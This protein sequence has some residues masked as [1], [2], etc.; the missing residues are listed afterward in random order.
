VVRLPDLASGPVVFDDAVTPWRAWTP[1][2]VRDVLAAAAPAARWAVAGGWAIDLHVGRPTRDHDDLEISVLATDVPAV[3]AAFPEPTWEWA[4]PID[5]RLH[6]PDPASSSATHQNWLWS[7]TDHAFVLDVFR[8]SHDGDTW[9]C[10]RAPAFRRPWSEV[11]RISPDGVPH[12]S[13]EVVLLFKAKYRREKDEADLR[14]VLPVL[15]DD[16][17]AWLAAALD[18]MHPGHPWRNRL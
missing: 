4:V 18:S 10:R 2:H 5:G 14:S 17:R 15:P 1:G 3:L 8:E 11:R 7:P 6:Q 9:I 13:A 16:R 12:L